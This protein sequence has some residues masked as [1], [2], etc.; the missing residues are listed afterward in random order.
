MDSIELTTHWKVK[1]KQ[2]ENRGD[3]QLVNT[4]KHP[5]TR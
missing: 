1:G 4:I 3:S 2:A 5:D